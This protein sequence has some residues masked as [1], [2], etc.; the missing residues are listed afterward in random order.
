MHEQT[1][2]YQARGRHPMPF[3]PTPGV[4]I[5]VPA[6][7]HWLATVGS[8]GQPRDGRCDAMYA[9]L[10][11]DTLALQFQRVPYDHQAAAQAIRAAGLPEANAR[12]LAQGR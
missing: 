2:F 8:V 7:R 10:D 11:T 12:R 4:P 5:P 6:H 1:L 3:T 9:L